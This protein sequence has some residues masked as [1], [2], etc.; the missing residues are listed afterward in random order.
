MKCKE[1]A[2]EGVLH[3]LKLSLAC[4]VVASRLSWRACLILERF[5]V[6]EWPET[7]FLPCIPEIWHGTLLAEDRLLL[8]EQIWSRKDP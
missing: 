5:G 1:R 2:G 6:R 3:G 8:N 4:P 7:G